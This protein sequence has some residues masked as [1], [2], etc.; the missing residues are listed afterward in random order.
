MIR[1]NIATVSDSVSMR[2]HRRQPGIS[3]ASGDRQLELSSVDH[4][5]RSLVEN[6]ENIRLAIL[7]MVDGNGHPYS[8][9]AIINGRYDAQA[10]TDCGYPV[11]PRYLGAQPPEN[12]GLPGAKVTHVWCDDPTDAAKV[13]KASFIPHVVRRPE[14]VIG[15]VDAVIIATDRGWEHVDRARPFIDAGLPVFIDKPLCDRVEDLRQF[16]AWHREGKAFL[17]TSATHY[18]K[19]YVA[20]RKEL[21][22]AVG[23]LRLLTITTAKSWE[24]YGI[25]ALE[26]VY[27]FLQPG[28]WISVA[29]T[30]TEQANIVHARHAAGVDVVLAAVA[31]MS[32]ASSK[33]N[34]YGTTGMLATGLL[35]TFHAFKAQ[36]VAFVD[37]LRTGHSPVPLSET[38]EM[39][40]IIIAGIRSRQDSGRTVMLEEI[41]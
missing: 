40:K 41:R 16:I 20:A 36:L 21:A 6:P 8:W 19:E 28:G 25:H 18:A 17:S 39:V 38:I 12:L 9:S 13:A 33:L 22:K 30:G 3:S 4:T 32:G 29:N 27:P 37:Y 5:S 26:A 23:Q 10:M 35:D 34:V 14:D 1:E 2:Q 24:R 15:A 7:G 31:D 11:I